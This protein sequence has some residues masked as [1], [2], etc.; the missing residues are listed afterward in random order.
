MKM[1]LK[2]CFDR[3]EETTVET[4]EET[5]R[6]IT[7]ETITYYNTWLIISI[8]IILIPIVIIAIIIIIGVIVLVNRS[9]NEVKQQSPKAKRGKSSIESQSSSK[10]SDSMDEV[11]RKIV[12]G[13]K[14]HIL[15]LKSEVLEK[16]M[17]SPKK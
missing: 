15:R 7:K 13:Q 14:F 6:E 2:E 5:T 4:T 9:K 8:V 3:I 12:P 1:A 17:L 11:A 10:Q 16:E